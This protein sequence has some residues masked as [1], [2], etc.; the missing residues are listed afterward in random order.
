VVVLLVSLV[1]FIAKLFEPVKNLYLS[2][3]E[4]LPPITPDKENNTQ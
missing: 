4:D 3:Y 2:L 1:M